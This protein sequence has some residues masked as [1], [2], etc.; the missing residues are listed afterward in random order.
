MLWPSS[1]QP[2]GDAAGDVVDHAEHG[3]DRRRVDRHVAGLV[4][5]RD[6]AA[7]DGDAELEASVAQ[8][9][10][11]LGELPH[12]L[13]VL[14]GAEVQAVADAHGLRAGD[15][16]VAVRLGE[17]ELRAL[18]RVEL[19]VATVGV[20]RDRDAEARL[21][22]DA[23]HAGVVGVAE[24]GVAEHVV[25]VL[26]GHPRGVGLVG[27]ADELQELLAQRLGPLGALERFGPS[28]PAA[29]RSTTGRRRGARRPGR[30]RRR[31]AG[32]RSRSPR[33]AT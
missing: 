18:A 22:V 26:V 6:V 24:R 2:D 28:R 30:R 1:C 13:G 4:V 19:R 11:G 9:L 17:R 8:A 33:R 29:R 31:C 23:H 7:G 3:D 10:D 15:G 5:E 14:G 32:R 20:G 27:R 21:L 12:D 16:D 25:V